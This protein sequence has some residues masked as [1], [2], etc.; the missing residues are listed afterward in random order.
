MQNGQHKICKTNLKKVYIRSIGKGQ[1]IKD[2]RKKVPKI[3]YIAIPSKLYCEK[4]KIF[5]KK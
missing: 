2:K 4:C 1:S 5:I 3:S